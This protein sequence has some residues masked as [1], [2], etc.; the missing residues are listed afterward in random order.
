MG[1]SLVALS[2]ETPEINCLQEKAQISPPQKQGSPT[3]WAPGI[4][5]AVQCPP[6]EH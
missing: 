3:F 5:V 2:R 4:P 6:K 1:L